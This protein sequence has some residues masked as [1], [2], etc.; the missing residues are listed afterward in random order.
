MVSPDATTSE[1][2]R[3]RDMGRVSIA[4]LRIVPSLNAAATRVR[5]RDELEIW[6]G[7]VPGVRWETIRPNGRTVVAGRVGLI[8][9][10]LSPLK[11]E[12][13]TFAKDRQ[14]S[15]PALEFDRQVSP[16]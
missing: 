12:M 5:F 2:T 14:E 15:P 13:R 9:R 7:L 3:Q 16:L 10:Q 4:G 6:D 11:V 1:K 8:V